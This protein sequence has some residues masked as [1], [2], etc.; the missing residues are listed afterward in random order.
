M[1]SGLFDRFPHVVFT[2]EIENI[3][4][5]VESILVILDFGIETRKVEAISK[6]FFVDLTEI[7]VAA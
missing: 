4:D 6:V 3:C 1:A 2:V 7:L 5:Q